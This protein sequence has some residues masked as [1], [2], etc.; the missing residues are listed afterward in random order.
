MKLNSCVRLHICL[1]TGLW[2]K[3]L[4][5]WLMIQKK[6]W[7]A[8]TWKYK[9]QF[10]LNG[11]PLLIPL[12][13]NQNPESQNICKLIAQ[14]KHISWRWEE[15]DKRT[16]P[17]NVKFWHPQVRPIVL[18]LLHST[19]SE[20]LSLDKVKNDPKKNLTGRTELWKMSGILVDKGEN[21]IQ[22]PENGMP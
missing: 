15:W 11:S 5:S 16:I 3:I 13:D 12:K 21:G 9:W 6:V 17:N 10:L 18:R 14:G 8:R 7:T 1:H 20:R 19:T 2:S 22:G 4:S